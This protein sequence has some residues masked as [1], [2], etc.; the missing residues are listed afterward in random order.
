MD[1]NMLQNPE[2]YISR[3]LSWLEFNQRVMEE[4][5]DKKNPLYYSRRLTPATIFF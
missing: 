3:E 5:K 4:A 1:A 2:Y